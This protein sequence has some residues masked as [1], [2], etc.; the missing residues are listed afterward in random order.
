MQC[1]NDGA[2]GHAPGKIDQIPAILRS[3]AALG[4]SAGPHFELLQQVERRAALWDVVVQFDQALA[5]PYCLFL[6]WQ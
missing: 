5:M 4:M 2:A 1:E 3:V 6:S